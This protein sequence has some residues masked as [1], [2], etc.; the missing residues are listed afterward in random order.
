MNSNLINTPS[1]NIQPSR[2]R[3]TTPLVQFIVF[4]VG[5]LNLA[6]PIEAV[7]K[8]FNQ[9]P[10]YGSGMRSVGVTHVGDREV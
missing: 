2:Q 8:V 10:I 7:Y 5:N 6:L 4:S 9:A 1:I 3:Q